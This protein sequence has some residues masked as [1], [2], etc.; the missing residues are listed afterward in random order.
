M[1]AVALRDKRHRAANKTSISLL[2]INASH[3]LEQL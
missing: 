3:G 1:D 2:G